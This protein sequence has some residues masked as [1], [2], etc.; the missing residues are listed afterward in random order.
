MINT[1][2]GKWTVIAW[3]EPDKRGCKRVLCKCECGF[4]KIQYPKDLKSNRTTKCNL[5]RRKPILINSKFGKWTVID[6]LVKNQ[7]SYCKVRCEC[8]N[9]SIVNNIDLRNYKSTKCRKCYEKEIGIRSKTHGLSRSP[10]YRIWRNMK[11]RCLRRK[12]KTYKYYGCRGISV[13]NRWLKF[14]NFLEDMGLKPEASNKYELDRIDN[15][16]NYEPNNCRWVTHRQNCHNRRKKQC[17]ND[18]L[19]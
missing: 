3:T 7:T 14:E 17:K 4:E 18:Y 2:F 13:C 5:C 16:G 10:T 9:E 11:D 1:K 19:I 8:G 12:N 6:N 15:N